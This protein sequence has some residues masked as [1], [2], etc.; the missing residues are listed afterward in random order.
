MTHYLQAFKPRENDPLTMLVAKEEDLHGNGSISTKKS[1]EK[2]VSFGDVCKII[3]GD[4]FLF[5]ALTPHEMNMHSLGERITRFATR[6]FPA[7]SLIEFMAVTK[8]LLAGRDHTQSN[9]YSHRFYKNGGLSPAAFRVLQ[10]YGDDVIL[11]SERTHFVG[12]VM[13][14]ATFIQMAKTF[15]RY[16][17]KT[18]FNL[19]FVDELSEARR[20]IEAEASVT[21]VFNENYRPVVLTIPYFNGNHWY[22]PVPVL[23]QPGDVVWNTNAEAIYLLNGFTIF[24]P[25]LGDK[26]AVPNRT[27]IKT[28]GNNCSA[29]T[30]VG[31]GRNM[32]SILRCGRR[33]VFLEP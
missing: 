10:R 28:T 19:D 32:H 7:P 9:E 22:P 3:F 1:K 23:L 5:Q 30:L 6:P 14:L 20:T 26:S 15:N 8:E 13:L 27:F 18:A 24:D 11:S 29:T 25:Q 4:E 17:E 31:Y 21:S 2:V 33:S 12:D 16:G